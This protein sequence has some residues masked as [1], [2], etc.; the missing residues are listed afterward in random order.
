M[1]VV[2]I[3]KEKFTLVRPLPNPNLGTINESVKKADIAVQALPK[4]SVNIVKPLQSEGTGTP[5]VIRRDVGIQAFVTCPHVLMPEEEKIIIDDGDPS[6]LQ[7][8]TLVDTVY[9]LKDQVRTLEQEHKRMKRD[10]EEEQKARRKLQS[11]IK[12][13][14]KNNN[15]IW[16]EAPT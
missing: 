9:S 8:K 1:S 5:N 2:A 11:T 10:L 6:N 4:E 3:A 13:V 16:E 12:K 14:F 7:E 15:L